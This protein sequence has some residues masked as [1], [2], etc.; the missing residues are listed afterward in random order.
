MSNQNF[1]WELLVNSLRDQE[2][3]KTDLIVAFIH[4]F[5]LK[6]NFR[7]IGIGD[8]RTLVPSDLET[9]SELLP[10][11]WNQMDGVY[12]LRYTTGG[13][14]YI[15][16]ALPS[17][18]ILI[19][20]LLNADNLSLSNVAFNIEETVTDPKEAAK[21]VLKDFHEGM[22]KLRSEFLEP[23]FK[24]TQKSTSAQ[25]DISTR[26]TTIAPPTRPRRDF[27]PEP[28]FG[29]VGRGDLDP[30]GRLGPGNLFE[31]PRFNP[32]DPFGPPGPLRGIPPGARFDPFGPPRGGRQRFEPDP[33]HQR[34]PG[35][36]DMFM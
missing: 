7:N 34:P 10:V 18:G 27:V 36:D 3:S 32:G 33:D 30:L 35:Y 28:G 21:N 26:F 2:T 22:E 11:G 6:H 25:T 5:L 9:A 20:N 15:L 24:R 29:G 12:K 16:N 13:K 8:D 1:G 19:A 23:V 31:P 4:F 17:E 14:I